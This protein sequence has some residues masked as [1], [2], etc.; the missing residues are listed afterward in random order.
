MTDAAISEFLIVTINHSNA[1]FFAYVNFVL[2]QL[3][4]CEAHGYIPVVFF[5]KHSVDGPNAYYDPAHGENMWDYYFEPVAGYTYSDI[6]ARLADPRDPLT[7]ANVHRLSVDKLWDLLER[8]PGSVYAYPHGHFKDKIDYDEA[9]YREQREKANRLIRQYIRV[10]PHVLSKVDAFYRTHFA[11]ERVLGV[12]IRGTDKGTANSHP[13]LMRIIKPEEYFPHIDKYTQQHGQ[14]RIFVATDQMQFLKEM[15]ERYGNRII[16]LPASRSHSNLATFNV[17]YQQTRNY[18]K[19]EEVLM[20][21]LLLSRC[22]YLLKCTSAVG[23]FAIYFNP[24]I[25]SRD[26]NYID[27]PHPWRTSFEVR[28]VKP[29]VLYCSGFTAARKTELRNAFRSFEQRARAFL[30]GSGRRPPF[31]E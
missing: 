3:L 27:D 28:F 7:A 1:G 24:A 23:E 20:D 13:K 30:G 29:F 26:L 11:G 17:N 15:R 6:E 12:Q 21:C 10:K 4:Y 8:C 2:N 5:G 19:G 16:S 14:C 18:A 22:D 31:G 9:W 25:E